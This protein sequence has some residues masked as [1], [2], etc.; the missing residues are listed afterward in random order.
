M[1]RVAARWNMAEATAYGCGGAQIDKDKACEIAG[2]AWQRHGC[3][4][5]LS[6]ETDALLGSCVW[7]L[8]WYGNLARVEIYKSF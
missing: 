7:L 2:L 6:V 5:L 3:A 8:N 1:K 4:V